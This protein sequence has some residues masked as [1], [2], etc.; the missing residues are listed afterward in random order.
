LAAPDWILGGHYKRRR[1]AGRRPRPAG[2]E[3]ALLDN[4]GRVARDESLL[5]AVERVL[6]QPAVAA[7][8]GA[9]LEAAE[10]ELASGATLM[11]TKEFSPK[12]GNIAEVPGKWPEG[13][14]TVRPFGLAPNAVMR[15]YERHP[16]SVQRIRVVSGTGTWHVLRG[17]DWESTTVLAT[18]IGATP[19]TTTVE[20]ARHNHICDPTD[21]HFVE[22]RTGG[23]AAPM[24]CLTWHEAA[25]VQDDHVPWADAAACDAIDAFWRRFAD[26]GPSPRL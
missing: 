18:P 6:A 16:N 21:V 12:L 26:D 4:A 17:A 5:F 24:L 2:R 25:A 22:N 13:V 19:L 1:R 15:I 3:A 11:Y 14:G 10:Q 8:F 20:L 23:G 9:L 7:F